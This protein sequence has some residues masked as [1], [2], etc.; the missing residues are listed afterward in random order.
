MAVQV[1]TRGAFRCCG[2]RVDA[3]V[4]DDAV[5]R[6]R[7]F[8]E[9]G[10]G[11]AV[12]LCNAWTLA[13]ARR[14]GAL[15]QALN[16]GDLNLPDG[17]PL[18]WIGRR[19]GFNHMRR[20]VYGPDLMLAAVRTGRIWGL[21]H[22]LYGSTPEVVD[23]LARRLAAITP[24]VQLVGAEAPPFRPLTEREEVELVERIRRV[25]PDV[26]WVG[27]GTP[28]QDLFVDRFRDRLGITLVAVGAAFD[29]LA[30]AKRQAPTWMQDCGLE[31]I[32]RLATEP[33]RLWRRYLIGNAMF[34][35]GLLHGVTIYRGTDEGRG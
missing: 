4:L 35:V 13:L 12:H 9:T 26:V 31:W 28:R 5:D 1:E 34:L 17:T 25:K 19:V 7:A 33:R 32:F 15:T 27:L 11:R 10:G 29:F 22:Y 20:R 21:R 16:R 2:V 23:A 14:D 18:T 6:L 8:I 3:V 30:G 24:G